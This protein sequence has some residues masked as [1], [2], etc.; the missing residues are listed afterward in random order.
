M[1]ASPHVLRVYKVS[2]AFVDCNEMHQKPQRKNGSANKLNVTATVRTN[3][4]ARKEKGS[5]S[6][7]SVDK[8]PIQTAVCMRKCLGGNA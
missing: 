1:S 3:E 4:V 7:P 5:A 8:T 2:S 6:A